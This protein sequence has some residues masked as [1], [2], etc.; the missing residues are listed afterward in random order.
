LLSRV[1]PREESETVLLFLRNLN[2]FEK[3]LLLK[4]F[5]VKEG[6]LL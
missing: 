6:I 2:N 5:H 4:L 3:S 1:W